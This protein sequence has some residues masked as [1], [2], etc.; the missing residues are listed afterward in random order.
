MGT[1][2]VCD[3]TKECKLGKA[4]KLQCCLSGSVYSSYSASTDTVA[5]KVCGDADWATTNANYNGDGKDLANST[6]ALSC[7]ADTTSVVSDDAKLKKYINANPCPSSGGACAFAEGTTTLQCC[8]KGKGTPLGG[9]E[10]ANKLG[11]CAAKTA[12]TYGEA[13]DTL[14]GVTGDLTYTKSTCTTPNATKTDID[15]SIKAKKCP[16]TGCE[17][18]GD[19]VYCCM[20]AD[21]TPAGATTDAQKLLKQ[22]Y[23][24]PKTATAAPPVA[25]S[26]KGATVTAKCHAALL[27]LSAAAALAVA[28]TI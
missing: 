20:T 11:F 14:I 24:A 18:V 4:K 17:K 25:G 9:T 16:T 23:C 6:G 13:T 2:T 15:T 8:M 5:V 12:T 7:S 22:K 3:G 19:E 10:N 26:W 28:T 27:T 21:V 1:K